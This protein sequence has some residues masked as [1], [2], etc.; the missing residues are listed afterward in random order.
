MAS[1]LN[2]LRRIVLEESRRDGGTIVGVLERQWW[3]T[4]PRVYAVRIAIIAR[5]RAELGLSDLKIEHLL[6]FSRGWVSKAVKSR[7]RDVRRFLSG[8]DHPRA[9]LTREQREEVRASAEPGVVLAARFGVKPP[10][11]SKI[12]RGVFPGARAQGGGL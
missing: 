12:R 8:S 5:A 3:E 4:T 11:I 10:A 6:G 9:K 7:R 2:P 1:G